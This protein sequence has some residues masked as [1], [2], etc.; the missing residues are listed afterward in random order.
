MVERG[1]RKQKCGGWGQE[2]K[3]MQGK[4]NPS[5]PTSMITQQQRRQRLFSEKPAV[6]DNL[7]QVD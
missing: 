5:P 4:Q 6:K 3:K 1:G 2:M 7:T